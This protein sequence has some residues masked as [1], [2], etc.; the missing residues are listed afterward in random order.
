M[1]GNGR[2]ALADALDIC[3]AELEMLIDRHFAVR[4][5]LVV[6]R[7]G[8]NWTA[9]IGDDVL[10]RHPYS[11]TVLRWAQT[12]AARNPGVSVAVG[13]HPATRP[14]ALDTDPASPGYLGHS[15]RV[16]NVTPIRVEA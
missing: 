8:S 13:D 12:F 6:E 7:E 11:L 2:T 15:V 3:T 4:R 10:Y 16:D 9:S 1:I 14:S 5:E